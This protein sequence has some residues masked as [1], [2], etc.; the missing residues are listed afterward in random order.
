MS[1]R[2]DDSPAASSRSGGHGQRTQNLYPHRDSAKRRHAQKFQPRRKLIEPA[3]FGASEE[4]KSDNAHGFLRVICAMTV[5][6]PCCAENLQL[7]KNGVDRA[8]GKT[9]ERN[10][11]DEQQK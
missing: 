10:E 11:E 6:H 7:P 9:M 3:G 2:A 4:R 8:R 1:E 5:R